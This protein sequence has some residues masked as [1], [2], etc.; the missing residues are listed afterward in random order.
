M[1][2]LIRV[3]HTP[4]Y[5]NGDDYE[6]RE[7]MFVCK[8]KKPIIDKVLKDFKFFTSADILDLITYGFM[9]EVQDENK[10]FC[11]IVVEEVLELES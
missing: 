10:C 1:F 7:V 4:N 2:V 5:D 11:N 8:N 3:T 9:D 6:H